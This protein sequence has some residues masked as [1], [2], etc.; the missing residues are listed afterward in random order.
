MVGALISRAQVVTFVELHP[1]SASA[2]VAFATTASQQAGY[3]RMDA[4][5]HAVTWAGTPES[6]VD[7]NPAVA[8]GSFAYAS[9]GGQQAGAAIIN[10]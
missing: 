6:V 5:W 1:A 4:V 10:N 9:Y 3:A 2:S 8:A 7:L